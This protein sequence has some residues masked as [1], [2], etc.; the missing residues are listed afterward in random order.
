MSVYPADKTRNPLAGFAITV[1]GVYASGKGT[2][3]KALARRWR[4]KFL[5]TGA[6]YR[7]VTWRVL[8]D[9]GNPADPGDAL[10]AA[11]EINFDFKH[12][13]NNE[14]G[15]WVDGV[16]V[17][18]E[19]RTPLISSQVPLVALQLPVRRALLSYQL[20]YGQHWKNLVGVVFDGRD[21][22]AR[23][24]PEAEVKLFLNASGEVRA[25][26]RWMEYV[27]RGKDITLQEVIT[28]M[29][30]RDARDAA[31][32]ICCPEAVEIDASDMD[33]PTVLRAAVAAVE[34][35]IGHFP[36]VQPDQE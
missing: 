19:I 17:S 13:G 16:E 35:K 6:I 25:R 10:R 26:R 32:T 20:N 1:D 33:I 22:G 31:N 21:T 3:C 14:F 34:A 36:P 24:C 9:G 11:Q 27:A 23:I 2:L 5:D 8:R 29:T 28:E 18:D 30:L 4:M 7:A 12:K 15:V